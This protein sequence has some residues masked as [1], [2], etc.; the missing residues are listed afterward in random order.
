MSTQF[1]T[2][3]QPA[4]TQWPEP[5]NTTPPPAAPV[6]PRRAHFTQPWPSVAAFKW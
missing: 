3:D 2:Q 6:H 1:Y 4:T 5:G